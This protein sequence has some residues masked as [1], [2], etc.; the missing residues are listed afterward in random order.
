MQIK[1][2]NRLTTDD[3]SSEEQIP[4]E[5]E[6]KGMMEQDEEGEHSSVLDTEVTNHNMQMMR[7]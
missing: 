5:G 1:S 6:E 4:V 3:D 2:Q 7:P